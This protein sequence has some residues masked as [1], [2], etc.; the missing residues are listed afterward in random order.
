MS[1]A[2]NQCPFFHRWLHIWRLQ[3]QESVDPEGQMDGC[4][5]AG[6]SPYY[7]V[8]ILLEELAY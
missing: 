5:V 6:G 4:T 8:H 3:L 7:P 1:A 2:G